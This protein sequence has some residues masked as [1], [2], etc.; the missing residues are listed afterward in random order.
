MDP[1]AD[2]TSSRAHGRGHSYST[3]VCF[4]FDP[5]SS[6][7]ARLSVSTSDEL[8]L[9]LCSPAMMPSNRLLTLC[10]CAPLPAAERWARIRRLLCG[11]RQHGRQPPAANH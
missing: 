11:R 8:D 4:S 6:A 7:V 9:A 3:N 1:D 10:F 5:M 2:S